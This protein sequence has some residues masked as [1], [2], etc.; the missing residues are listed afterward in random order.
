MGIPCY[1]KTHRLDRGGESAGEDN[2]PLSYCR[3]PIS[4]IKTGDK[5][6]TAN[7][8]NII[9]RLPGAFP[10]N[11]GNIIKTNGNSHWR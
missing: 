3:T 7:Y 1:S 4:Y 6:I 11:L 5:L 10:E 2:L 8:F 9:N